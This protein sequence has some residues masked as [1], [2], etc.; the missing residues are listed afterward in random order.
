MSAENDNPASQ[1]SLKIDSIIH[2]IEQPPQHAVPAF[3]PKGPLPVTQR[4]QL[5]TSKFRENVSQFLIT[6]K[7]SSFMNIF[8]DIMMVVF[9]LG[10]TAAILAGVVYLIRIISGTG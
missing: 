9:G 10:S 6:K 7:D 8:I 4:F 3:K 5:S 2:L 1:S